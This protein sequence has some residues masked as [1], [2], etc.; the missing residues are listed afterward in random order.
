MHAGHSGK[1]LLSSWQLQ[2]F[3]EEG[4]I[5][6]SLLAEISVAAQPTFT[7]LVE[8]VDNIYVLGYRRKHF[9]MYI[10]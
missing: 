9:C 7:Y 4:N 6:D 2:F 3:G 10:C 8:I 1:V 5:R